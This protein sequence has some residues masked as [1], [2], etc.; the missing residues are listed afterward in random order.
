MPSG[1]RRACWLYDRQVASQDPRPSLPWHEA[2]AYALTGGRWDDLGTQQRPD[3]DAVAGLIDARHPGGVPAL[4]AA[5][6]ARRAAGEPW[7]HPLPD[8]LRRGLGAAQWLAALTGLRN[9]LDLDPAPDRPV[10]SDRAPDAEER[11]LLAEVPPHH[12]H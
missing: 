8:D 1:P 2:L 6:A 11:R 7:P 5:V 3:L 4:R 10:L 12:G 9:L